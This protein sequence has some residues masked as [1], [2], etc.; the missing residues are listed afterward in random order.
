MIGGITPLPHTYSWR[1]AYLGTEHVF[2]RG[3]QLSTG[4]NL[5]LPAGCPVRKL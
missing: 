3:T 2:M 1:G 5:S 4:T